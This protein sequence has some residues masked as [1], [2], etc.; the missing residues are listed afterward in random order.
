MIR[1]TRSVRASWRRKTSPR[2]QVVGPVEQEAPC[3]LGERRAA[4]LA[5]Q[6]RLLP[7]TTQRLREQG[8]LR[9]LAG[10]LDPSKA[11]KTPAAIR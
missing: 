5:H 7:A 2:G 8:H 6:H 3:L 11:M 9:A 4:G 1:R 10:P